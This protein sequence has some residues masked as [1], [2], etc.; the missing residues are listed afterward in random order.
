[1]RTIL[2][3]IWVIFAGW[4]LFLGYVVAGILLAEAP[5]IFARQR[6][7]MEIVGL[8]RYWLSVPMLA[9]SLITLSQCDS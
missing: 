8:S 1:M 7:N 6:G 5:Q 4:V 9:S 3:I 2:N